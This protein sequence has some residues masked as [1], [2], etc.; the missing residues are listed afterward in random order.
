MKRIPI[1]IKNPVHIEILESLKAI[2][3]KDS[4]LIPIWSKE[5]LLKK[6]MKIFKISSYMGIRTWLM[7]NKHLMEDKN[8]NQKTLPG[9]KH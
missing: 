2:Y 4:D 1:D 8:K 3:R 7:E 9:K 5:S 6:I